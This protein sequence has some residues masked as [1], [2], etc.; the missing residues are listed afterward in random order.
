MRNK[1]IRYQ[2]FYRKEGEWK[3]FYGVPVFED[4][5]KAGAEM[6]RLAHI[7]PKRE[8]NLFKCEKM[9]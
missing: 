9:V 5:V 4:N 2:V 6:I 1:L 3:P 8:F 7:F